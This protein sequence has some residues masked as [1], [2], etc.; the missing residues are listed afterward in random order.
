MTDL[1]AGRCALAATALLC[2]ASMP[3]HAELRFGDDSSEWAFDGECDDPRFIGNGMADIL[4]EEDLFAD[5]SDCQQLFEAGLIRLRVGDSSVPGAVDFGVDT[6]EWIFDGEC[7][8]PRFVGDGMA[9]VLLEEDRLAD[10]T[11]C[12]LLYESGRIRL[13][14]DGGKPFAGDS[15]RAQAVRQGI[16]SYGA[17]ESGDDILDDGEYCDY[18]SFEGHA[19]AL[20][21]VVLRTEEFDPYLIVRA[22]SGEQIDNDDH[23]GDASRSLVTFPMHEDGIYTVGV[24]SYEA[25]EVGA[26]SLLVQIQ[27]DAPT[28]TAVPPT[29]EIGV[30]SVA[31]GRVSG[32]LL[33]R[34]DMPSARLAIVP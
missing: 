33:A 24:T 2:A 4:L 26:Y 20:A 34:T 28:P 27:A 29:G 14:A 10:A 7:D 17:L 3:S 1:I 32:E 31:P 15:V 18:F 22:P 13:R 19:G 6:S 11:D 23:E 30:R 25:G 12:R 5:A 21:V 9:E 16:A 8:D